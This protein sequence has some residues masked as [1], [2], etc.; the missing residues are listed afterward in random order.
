MENTEKK[1]DKSTETLIKELESMSNEALRDFF[2]FFYKLNHQEFNMIFPE[3]F[4]EFLAAF[5]SNPFKVN[6][7]KTFRKQLIENLIKYTNDHMSLITAA[8]LIK[9]KFTIDELIE[10]YYANFDVFE[11][12]LF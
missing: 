6:E 10:N 1:I 5:D 9:K 8:I 2:K 3:K 11:H 12:A 4:D 7:D